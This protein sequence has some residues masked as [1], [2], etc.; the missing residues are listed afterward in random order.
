MEGQLQAPLRYIITGY[1]PMTY[2]SD[3]IRDEDVVRVPGHKHTTYSTPRGWTNR[4]TAGCPTY[5]TC[6]R[7]MMCGP[8][9]EC[10]HRCGEEYKYLVTFNQGQTV[11]S[12]AIAEI[13]GSGQIRARANRTQDWLQT[14]MQNLTTD[15]FIVKST[16]NTII[17]EDDTKEKQE[18]IR[19]RIYNLLG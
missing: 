5:G 2:G 10:C 19:S 6:Q 11:D 17:G 7:C 18:Q 12:I 3:F 8:V 4:S 15:T 1:D 14:P 16:R 9:D 13:Y